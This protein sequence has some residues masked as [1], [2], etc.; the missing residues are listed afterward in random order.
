MRMTVE[1]FL[2]I[3]PITGFKQIKTSAQKFKHI[4]ACF[5]KQL[6]YLIFKPDINAGLLLGHTPVVTACSN[7]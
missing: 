2:A 4:Q 3:Q 5:W 1:Q 7:L 6:P